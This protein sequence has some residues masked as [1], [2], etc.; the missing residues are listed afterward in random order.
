M[1]RKSLNIAE[2]DA[3]AA[4]DFAD[5]P[6]AFDCSTVSL[7]Y[8]CPQRKAAGIA[9]AGGFSGLLFLPERPRLRRRTEQTGTYFLVDQ[10][11]PS[12]AM[13]A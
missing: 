2:R 5:D 7:I 8:K 4:E 3:D 1:L 11:V 12:P 9:Q 6:T 13:W 10:P